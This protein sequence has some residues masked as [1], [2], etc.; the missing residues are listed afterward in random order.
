MAVA[1][2]FGGTLAL[3]IMTTVFNNTSGIGES[4]PFRD[5]TTLSSL[6]EPLKSQ[7]INSAKVRDC[8]IFA[9]S[10]VKLT[11]TSFRW[12]LFGRLSPSRLSMWQ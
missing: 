12:E 2:P 10:W 4:S 3:T 1:L 8:Y 9:A 11:L 6:P 7:V 5:F